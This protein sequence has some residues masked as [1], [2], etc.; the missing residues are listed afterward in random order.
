M[1]KRASA[2]TAHNSI[3]PRR[4]HYCRQT[5]MNTRSTS[6]TLA[7]RA[8]FLSTQSATELLVPRAPTHNSIQQHCLSLQPLSPKNDSRSP[9]ACT[10]Q[11]YLIRWNGS[12][13]DQP[14]GTDLPLLPDALWHNAPDAP[15]YNYKYQTLQIPARNIKDLFER[16]KKK[17]SSFS[18]AT[19]TQILT[20][21]TC[22][23]RYISSYIWIM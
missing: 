6:P 23:R 1:W 2:A 18:I 16:R 12:S 9:F 22:V 4:Q 17:K 11:I 14:V 10:T 20:F 13:E 5:S 8:A 7:C 21:Y 3:P 19:K 15:A